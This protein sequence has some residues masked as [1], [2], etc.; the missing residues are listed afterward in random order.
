M[1]VFFTSDLHLGHENILHLDGRPFQSIEENDDEILKRWNSKVNSNDTV[2]ILG[3]MIWKPRKGKTI[4]QM[5]KEFNGHKILIKGNHDGRIISSLTRK[6]FS[7]IKDYDDIKVTLQDKTVKR[8]ILSHYPI[9]FYN[10]HY[11]NA[12]MLYGHVHTTKEYQLTKE[13]ADWLNKNGCPVEMYN[14][15]TMIW[16]YE[17]VTLDEILARKDW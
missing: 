3:D 10:G 8:C 13:Y 7:D 14:V 17:P 12:I 9:H 5:L 15:G 16:N 1:S 4:V 2:Y 11:S 6:E